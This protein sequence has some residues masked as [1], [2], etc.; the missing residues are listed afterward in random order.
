MLPKNVWLTSNLVRCARAAETADFV[1]DRLAEKS[2]AVSLTQLAAFVD[3]LPRIKTDLARMQEITKELRVNASQ[4][5]DGLR[6]VKKVLLDTLTRC[7]S[8][9]CKDIL[10]NYLSGK[11]DINGID[12]NQVRVDGGDKDRRGSATTTTT[13]METVDGGG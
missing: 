1:I 7:P 5:S 2:Q 9:S 8:Q 4:L 11:L 13:T 12:Y 10:S 3:A 6:G